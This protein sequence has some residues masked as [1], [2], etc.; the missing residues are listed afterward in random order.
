MAALPSPAMLTNYEIYLN[1]TATA[2]KASTALLSEASS[3]TG[4]TTTAFKVKAGGLFRVAN[5]SDNQPKIWA[6]QPLITL[7]KSK[8]IS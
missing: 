8:V 7:I 2:L 4:C 6:K 1:Q 3:Q 5:V